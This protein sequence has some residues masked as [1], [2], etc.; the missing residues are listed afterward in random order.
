MGEKRISLKFFEFSFL[1]LCSL[2]LFYF[3]RKSV[4]LQKSSNSIRENSNIIQGSSDIFPGG[5]IFFDGEIDRAVVKAIENSTKSIDAA[6]YTF[7]SGLVR[8]ALEKAAERGVKVRV[9]AGKLK[10]TSSS[11]FEIFQYSPGEGIF[12]EKFLLIDSNIAIISSKN[13]TSTQSLNFAIFFYETPQLIKHLQSEFENIVYQNDERAC[14]GGCSFEYGQLFFLPGKGCV[15]IKKLLLSAQ[16]SINLAMYTITY[17]TP[18]TVGLKGALRKGVTVS[19]IVDD[20]KGSDKKIVNQRAVRYLRSLGASISFDNF[21]WNERELLFHHKAAVID[22]ERLIFGSL[23]WTKSGCYK[24][25]ELLI[26]LDK[27]SIS[28]LVENKMN[29]YHLLQNL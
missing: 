24:N 4:E 6:T 7:G 21:D 28:S 17:A 18:M 10:S 16:K 29:H 8:N 5:K 1:I 25:R 19:G 12:H 3:S 14:T 23:N 26:I 13:L 15:E 2:A 11:R 9:L 20:W 27:K 22:S